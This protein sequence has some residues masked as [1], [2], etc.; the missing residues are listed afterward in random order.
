MEDKVESLLSRESASLLIKVFFFIVGTSRANVVASI[1][2]NHFNQ[3]LQTSIRQVP[4][5]PDRIRIRV[6]TPN[7][8]EMFSEYYNEDQITL[9]SE[10]QNHFFF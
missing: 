5:L 10:T 8:V 3:N 4:L 7:S 2:V 1:S 9:F 6:L